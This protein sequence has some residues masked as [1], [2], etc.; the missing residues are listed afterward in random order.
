MKENENVM[1]AKYIERSIDFQRPQTT[2]AL[3]THYIWYLIADLISVSFYF[4]FVFV[5]ALVA[6]WTAEWGEK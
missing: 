5:E 2:G 6:L 3:S 1:Q 4:I